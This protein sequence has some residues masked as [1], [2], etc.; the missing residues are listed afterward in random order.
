M[1]SPNKI[2]VVEDED[3]L[4]ENL[5]AFLSRHAHDVRVASNAS[6]ALE[7]LKSFTP[8]VVVL[9]YRLPDI[10]GLQAYTEI[11]HRQAPLAGCVMITGHPTENISNEAKE[12]GIQHILGKPFSFKDLQQLVDF[13]ADDAFQLLHGPLVSSL[14]L[15]GS[16]TYSGVNRRLND[17]SA[18]SFCW[19]VVS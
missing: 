2:L 9:D 11:V 5:Q 12:R 18:P 6:Q 14:K 13:C 8:N 15:N 10:D 16:P 7:I 3:K 4:A 17:A 1:P 19:S